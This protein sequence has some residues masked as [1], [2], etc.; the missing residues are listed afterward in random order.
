MQ[1]YNTSSTDLKVTWQAPS[2]VDKNGVIIGYIVYYQ[3]VS[4][5]YTDGTLRTKQVGPVLETVLNGLEKYVQYSINVSALTSAGEGPSS[6]S[7]L[8]RTAEDGK[9][10]HLHSQPL[11]YLF[12]ASR[13]KL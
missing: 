13:Q 1:G 10:E 4:G 12:Q 9:K 11:C 5:G 3:A 2:N 6:S 8:V 7:I